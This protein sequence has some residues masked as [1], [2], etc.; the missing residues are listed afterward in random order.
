MGYVL[1]AKFTV[2]HDATVTTSATG[3]FSFSTTAPTDFGGN[4]DIYAV[5]NGV[6]LAHGG[7]D[8]LRTLTVS[9]RSGPIGTPI[10]VTYTSMDAS[11]YTGGAEVLWDNHYTGEMHGQLDSRH[12]VSDVIRA[13]GR[14]AR[15]SSRSATRSVTVPQRHPVTDPR[16][17]RRH[18]QVQ[19]TKGNGP[20][21]AVH[22]VAGQRGAHRQSS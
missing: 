16:H 17:Q 14:W 8:L 12:R 22:H 5:Q 4:H 21:E 9:P 3:S 1:S 10:T 7:F 2:N 11:V 19:V 6:G 15:T 20:A 18:G 13:A